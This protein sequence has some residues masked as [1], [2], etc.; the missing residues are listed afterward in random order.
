MLHREFMG[1]LGNIDANTSHNCAFT[2][3]T[4]DPSHLAQP[5]PPGHRLALNG[6]N[7]VVWFMDAVTL[8]NEVKVSDPW[9]PRGAKRPS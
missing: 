3:L 5:P 9:K 7:H 1:L 8:F 6:D 2:G 4:Q